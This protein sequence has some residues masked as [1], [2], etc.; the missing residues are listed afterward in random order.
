MTHQRTF[1][2]R[3]TWRPWLMLTSCMRKNRCLL[4]SW[5]PSSSQQRR[6]QGPSRQQWTSD[7]PFF[8][9]QDGGLPIKHSR[10][11]LPGA[12]EVSRGRNSNNPQKLSQSL[13]PPSKSV[14]QD[15]RGKWPFSSRNR[16]MTFCSGQNILL[17]AEK[18][19]LI[20]SQSPWT[21]SLQRTL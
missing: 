3:L 11:I 12:L 20:S 15:K 9:S 2:N 16:A 17:V 18:N 8:A 14:N 7:L 4:T 19:M 21:N 6:R 13:V 5:S 1:Q 10:N